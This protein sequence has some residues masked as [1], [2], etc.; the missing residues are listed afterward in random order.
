MG[1]Y[2]DPITG[3]LR[4]YGGAGNWV[5]PEMR[6]HAFFCDDFAQQLLP[7]LDSGKSWFTA[8]EI[9]QKPE[10]LEP[11]VTLGVITKHKSTKHD[12]HYYKRTPATRPFLLTA[13]AL[14]DERI[15]AQSGATQPQQPG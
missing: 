8:Y 7:I 12:G 5:T 3:S 4:G 14:R 15:R 9:R 11:L 1:G 10:F 13:L 6:S 2:I